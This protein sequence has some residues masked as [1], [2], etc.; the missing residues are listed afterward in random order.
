ME[1]INLGKIVRAG[2]QVF[3][4]WT[5]SLWLWR[6]FNTSQQEEDRQQGQSAGSKYSRFGRLARAAPSPS[7]SQARKDT[8]RGKARSRGEEAKERRLM[9]DAVRWGGAL[10]R[11]ERGDGGRGGG[12]WRAATVWM[13]TVCDF[14]RPIR[15]QGGSIVVEGVRLL[16][17]RCTRPQGNGWR[18]QTEA[19]Q[20]GG[21]GSEAASPTE[22]FPGEEVGSSASDIQGSQSHG[23][24]RRLHKAYSRA[25]RIYCAI[26]MGGV[27][28]T[29]ARCSTRLRSEEKGPRGPRLSDGIEVEGVPLAG[30]HRG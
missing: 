10:A 18:L 13:G 23:D 26:C 27:G 24:R 6:V 21:I 15:E 14:T 22:R 30:W 8:L 25:G 4:I 29:R 20:W 12:S 2:L 3:F 9:K 19:A 11:R 5:L 7:W 17:S 1:K 28:W 16:S